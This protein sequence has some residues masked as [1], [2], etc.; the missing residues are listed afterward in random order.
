MGLNM[1]LATKEMTK[2]EYSEL[3]D[4]EDDIY[5]VTFKTGEPSYCIELDDVF[6]LEVGVFTNLPTGFRIFNYQKNKVKTVK[7]KIKMLLDKVKSAISD[8]PQPTFHQRNAVVR[9]A[10]EKVL[11]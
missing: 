7:I 5:Y 9:D 4:Q 11:A 8:K 2:I 1:K 6:L 10:L 3:Y